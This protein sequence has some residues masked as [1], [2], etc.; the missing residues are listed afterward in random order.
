MLEGLWLRCVLSR[1]VD[2]EDDMVTG[3]DR[4][5]GAEGSASRVVGKEQPADLRLY[6][7][8][9]KLNKTSCLLVVLR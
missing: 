4:N 9:V 5:V 6:A 7:S 8:M 3:V 2:V 1:R